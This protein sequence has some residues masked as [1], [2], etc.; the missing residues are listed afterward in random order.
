MHVE[1]TSEGKLT[2]KNSTEAK[3][4]IFDLPREIIQQIVSY[5][6]LQDICQLGA[7]CRHGHSLTHD[8]DFWEFQVWKQFGLYFTTDLNTVTE[9]LAKTSRYP[10]EGLAY[11]PSV[12]GNREISVIYSP[13]FKRIMIER[14]GKA[15]QDP[16]RAKLANS[17]KDILPRLLA[18]YVALPVG[19]EDQF[20]ARLV[21]FGPGI[22]S[23]NTKLLVR[24][25]VNARSSTFDAVEFIKG[26][27]GGIGSG[28]KINY[29]HMYN[30]DLM[31]LYSNSESIRETVYHNRNGARLDP[32]L[33]RMLVKDSMGKLA[34]QPSIVKLLP[35]LHALVFAIDT[36]VDSREK[37]AEEVEGMRKE[38]GVMLESQSK[39]NLCIPLLVLACR[40]ESVGANCF[41]S[42]E[43]IIV[44]LELLEMKSP[45]G[46]FEVCCENMRGV[47]KGLD[48]V[49]HHLAKKRRELSYH[50]MQGQSS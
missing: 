15:K 24:R 29:N 49:L 40:N 41:I 2:T 18:F 47:E 27:P 36:A 44:G 39:F 21:L 20:S 19:V 14:N 45:W 3:T 30:F 32:N 50:S 8:E 10:L 37:V 22:E 33:N 17:I 34:I 31:C 9:A 5:L 1:N 38:L 13:E 7:T 6:S 43:E 35:T 16:F 11:D 28:V 12:Q 48:W 4:S 46:V 25:M 26:L 23:A 42:L